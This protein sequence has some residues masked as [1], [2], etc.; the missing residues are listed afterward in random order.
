MPTEQITKLLCSGKYV[1]TEKYKDE[2]DRFVDWFHPIYKLNR[3]KG[4]TVI[5]MES[6]IIGVTNR[7]FI[8]D[9]DGQDY[10][11]KNLLDVPV[12]VLADH[13]VI[14]GCYIYNDK[15]ISSTIKRTTEL[16]R[17]QCIDRVDGEDR[18]YNAYILADMIGF[19]PIKFPEE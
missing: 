8:R 16:V 9:S 6:E 13:G 14:Y 3:G 7:T 2:F 10:P 1:F 18:Y 19:A 15:K 5:V 12:S 11:F 4:D 17:T